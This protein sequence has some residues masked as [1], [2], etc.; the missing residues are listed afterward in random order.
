MPW[1]PCRLLLGAGRRGGWQ[2]AASS[3]RECFVKACQGFQKWYNG[4]SQ[5]PVFE[6]KPVPFMGLGFG[7]ERFFWVEGLMQ[8]TYFLE[9]L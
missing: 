5:V 6:S 8:E 2:G 4:F 7:P 9:S 1:C 3:C